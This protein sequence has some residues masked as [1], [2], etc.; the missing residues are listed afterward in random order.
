MDNTSSSPHSLQN[1]MYKHKNSFVLTDVWQRG[2][3][4]IRDQKK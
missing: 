3:E 2:T 4:G 1:V